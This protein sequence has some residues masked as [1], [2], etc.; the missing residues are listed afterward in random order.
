MMKATVAAITTPR[1]TRLPCR[2]AGACASSSGSS[3]IY[4]S[5]AAGEPGVNVLRGNA[6]TMARLLD[7]Q[8]ALV[9]GGGKGIGRAIA[10]ELSAGGARVLVTGRDERALGE[11]VGEIAHGGGQARHLV[12][13]VREEPHARAAAAKATEI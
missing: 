4:G 12:G 9:T 1:A 10:L 3:T 6:M 11:T 2:A 13:D 7:G 5:M 8:V